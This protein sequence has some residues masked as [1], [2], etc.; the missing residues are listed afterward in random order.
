MADIGTMKIGSLKSV[1]AENEHENGGHKYFENSL[2]YCEK[3][4]DEKSGG[5]NSFRM[6]SEL[7]DKS[8]QTMSGCSETQSDVFKLQVRDRQIF[9]PV[10]NSHYTSESFRERSERIGNQISSERRFDG[11]ISSLMSTDEFKQGNSNS[12]DD[13]GYRER[14]RKNNE[15][16]K[17]SRDARRAKE[18]EIAI[19]AAYLEQ[20]NLRLKIE[21]SK[22]KN[23]TSKL[24]CL[25]YNIDD[26][27]SN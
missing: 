21:L 24:T 25:L 12:M 23:E 9:W 15:A 14:R 27:I 8:Q 17:R 5:S 18:D 26:Y 20:E 6:E 1:R 10:G 13:D 19:R 16:A 7:M 4:S 11:S 3:V 2:K 22:I